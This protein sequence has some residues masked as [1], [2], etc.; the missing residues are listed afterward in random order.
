MFHYLK[1]DFKTRLQC[2]MTTVWIKNAKRRYGAHVTKCHI[3]F[4]SYCTCRS[5]DRSCIDSTRGSNGLWF[6]CG[7]LRQTQRLKGSRDSSSW[8][9]PVILFAQARGSVLEIGVGTGLNLEKYNLSKLQLLTLV[10]VSQG[11]LGEATKRFKKFLTCKRSLFGLSRQ[12]PCPNWYR[13]MEQICLTRLL[14]VSLFVSYV[15][16][17]RR[18]A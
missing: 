8:P 13:D 1:S 2:G 12:M 14:I 10:D 7:G 4:G 18:L 15:C 3:L 11:M 16:R 9:S 5:L 6:L 17:G